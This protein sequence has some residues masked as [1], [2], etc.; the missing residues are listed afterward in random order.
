VEALPSLQE[1]QH[2]RYNAVGVGGLSELIRGAGQALCSREPE[3]ST[4]ELATRCQ[5][6]QMDG[7]IRSSIPAPACLP[8]RS[9]MTT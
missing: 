7:V 3:N 4:V 8:M 9:S 2:A 1:C 6:G 5:N